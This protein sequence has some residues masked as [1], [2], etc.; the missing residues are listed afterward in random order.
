MA[1]GVAPIVSN[2]V[3]AF[4]WP[5]ASVDLDFIR[6]QYWWNGATRLESAF[7]TLTLNGATWTAQGLDF[8][9]CTANPDITITL[10]TLAITMP[11]CVYAVGGYF[12]S[13]PAANKTLYQFDDAT[14]NERFTLLLTTAPA[15]SMQVVDG[16]VQQS[17]QS[18][19][20]IVP[21]TDRFGI[22]TS[23][24]LNDVKAA[25][26]GVGAGADTAATMPTVTVLSFG[27]NRTVTTFPP[28]AIS[29]MLIFPA[30]KTQAEI[31]QLSAQIRDTP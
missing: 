15:M 7:T 1:L 17:A 9:A 14:N 3:I 28:A 11:P 31:N 6:R 27:H 29:R 16:N 2:A 10:A 30:V 20:S 22:A 26:Q 18:P 13:T 25:G 24:A 12:I 19:G 5:G 4:P 23:A 8:S 21:A